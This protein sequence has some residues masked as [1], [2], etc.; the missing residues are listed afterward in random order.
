MYPPKDCAYKKHGYGTY[1]YSD[2]ESWYGKWLNDK[3][4]D[5]K[6]LTDILVA[7][8]IEGITRSKTGIVKGVFV[9]IKGVENTTVKSDKEGR[10]RIKAK[11]GQIIIFNKLGYFN[12][13]YVVTTS[14]SNTY[15]IFVATSK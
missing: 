8:T 7:R 2:G 14:S 3:Q 10:Y 15:N 5:N 6:E 1:N 11:P 12:K 4:V 9:Y 13:S